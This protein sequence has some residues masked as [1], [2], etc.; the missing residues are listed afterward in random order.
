MNINK[1]T[2][3]SKVPPELLTEQVIEKYTSLN[4]LFE[5]WTTVPLSAIE[6]KTVNDQMKYLVHELQDLGITCIHC[7]HCRSDPDLDRDPDTYNTYYCTYTLNEF[8][9]KDGSLWYSEGCPGLRLTSLNSL[10]SCLK[11]DLNTCN[12]PYGG[13][14][15][16]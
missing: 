2:I 15:L 13:F 10:G 7:S 14:Q 5:R 6:C 11:L 1:G 3:K 9:S 4:K 12:D 8:T 16:F